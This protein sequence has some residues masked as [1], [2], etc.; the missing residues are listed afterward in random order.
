MPTIQP[1]LRRTLRFSTLTA[2]PNAALWS[3][4]RSSSRC[5]C[6]ACGLIL[7][8]GLRR[9]PP[10]NHEG[11]LRRRHPS[12]GESRHDKAEHPI[13]PI[14]KNIKKT[15]KRLAKGACVGNIG[16]SS[17]RISQNYREIRLLL[18]RRSA[19]MLSIG[20]QGRYFSSYFSASP[21]GGFYCTKLP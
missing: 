13:L 10:V 5:D 3:G 2:T 7:P 8:H 19:L 18:A 9:I 15:S 4:K 1:M 14:Q 12:S 16:V 17:K 11:P 21:N 6:S 20:Q